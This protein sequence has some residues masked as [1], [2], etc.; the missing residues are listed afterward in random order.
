MLLVLMVYN[1]DAFFKAYSNWCTSNGIVANPMKSN[2]LRFNSAVSVVSI[3]GH[4]LENPH[5]VKYLGVYIDNKL[6]WTYQVS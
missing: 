3:N 5:V 1:Q 4:L 2:Y 6:S